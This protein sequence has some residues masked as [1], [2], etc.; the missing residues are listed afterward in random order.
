[1]TIMVSFLNTVMLDVKVSMVNI[2][3]VIK[4]IKNEM[5]TDRER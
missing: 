3:N 2:I 4:S 5:D 1:M